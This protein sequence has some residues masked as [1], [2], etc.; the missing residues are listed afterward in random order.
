MARYIAAFCAAA[1]LAMTNSASAGSVIPNDMGRC[2]ADQGP[3]VKVIINGIRSSNGR[4]R[5]QSYPATKAA[6]LAKGR[7]LHRIE[8]GA[9]AGTMSFT[10]KM[11]MAT[12][13]FPRME[14]VFRTIRRSAS[15]IWENR[16]LVG[17][18][19]MQMRA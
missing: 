1:A 11:A 9:R 12:Q 19:F 14:A 4:V 7:W 10:T 17:S 15:S 6:W 2:A 5:V 18:V 13:I 3:A 8:S 16:R